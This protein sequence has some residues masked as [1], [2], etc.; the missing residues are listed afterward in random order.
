MASCDDD[1]H[2]LPDDHNHHHQRQQQ[3]Q[4]QSQ[5]QH[6]GFYRLNRFVPKVAAV[7]TIVPSPIDGVEHIN[8]PSFISKCDSAFPD[9]I[10]LS[11]ADDVDRRSGGS[12]RKEREEMSDGGTLYLSKRSKL[13]GGGS[14]T[15]GGTDNR[16][17]RE[18]WNDTAI[19]CLLDA[20][21]EKF[22]Q[23]NWG[24]LRGR[25]WEEVARI[26][27]ERCEKQSKSVEQCK[28]KVDNLKKRYKLEKHRMNICGVTTSHWPWFKKMEEIYEKSLPQKKSRFEED[29]SVESSSG[30]LK[31]YI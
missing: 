15:P 20:F 31:R 14:A 27:K 16:K 1:F 18:E 9:V 29:K 26:V 3:R 2:L 24:N 4:S 13:G 11:D 19:E 22:A 12:G 23:L 5:F 28:N 7:S 25:D 8:D 17:D 6:Q 21:M 30:L 10:P